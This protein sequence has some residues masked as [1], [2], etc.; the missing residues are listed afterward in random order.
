VLSGDTVVLRHKAGPV[1]GQPP[2]ERCV[3][4]PSALACGPMPAR[5]CQGSPAGRLSLQNAPGHLCT[6]DRS[7]LSVLHLASL[8]SPRLGSAQ[9]ED[10]PYAF[11]AREFVRKLVVGKEVAFKVAT[12]VGGS[13][14]VREIGLV[15]RWLKL[16]LG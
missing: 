13:N 2:K 10:E 14:G 4:L 8:S 3:R 15:L 7:N 1:N 9:R 12:S 11:E 5:T 6:R 16:R